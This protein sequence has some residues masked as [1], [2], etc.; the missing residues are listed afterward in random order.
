MSDIHRGGCLCGA[1][2]YSVAGALAPVWACHCSQC[3]KTSGH[4]VASTSARNADLSIESD[5]GLLT[6]YASSEAAER[7]F[8]A[9]CGS[10]LF[11]REKAGDHTSIGAG[12][13]DGNT[14]LTLQGH[15]FT[16]DKGDYYVLP[17]HE[18]QHAAWPERD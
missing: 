4:F 1:V 7:G 17:E 14:G 2:R 8:C 12:T 10:S 11:W 3:R 15:I 6:W 5:G 16:A 9:R 13:L 18:V